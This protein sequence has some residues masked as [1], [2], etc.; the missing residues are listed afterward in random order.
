MGSRAGLTSPL[1][2]DCCLQVDINLVMSTGSSA[3]TPVIRDVSGKGL[4]A[5]AG[6]L[7]YFE[8]VLFTEDKKGKDQPIDL[9]TG[10]FTI[11][12]LG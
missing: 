8:E 9:S 7:S 11:H 6:E 12:N 3:V 5:I 2:L 1:S 10:T 4:S